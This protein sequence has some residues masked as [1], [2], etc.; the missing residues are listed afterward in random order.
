MP[1]FSLFF[2]DFIW[3]YTTSLGVIL[4]LSFRHNHSLFAFTQFRG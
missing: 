4:L 1:P 2:W 3:S